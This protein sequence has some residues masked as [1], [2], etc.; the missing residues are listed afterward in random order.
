VSYPQTTTFTTG[1]R[2]ILRKPPATHLSGGGVHEA[3]LHEAEL[4]TTFTRH[5]LSA[6]STSPAPIMVT[7]T[8]LPS[9]TPVAMSHVLQ[10]GLGWIPHLPGAR[11]EACFAQ[12]ATNKYAAA[13]ECVKAAWRSPPGLH[14]TRVTRSL[15]GLVVALSVPR[16]LLHERATLLV[17]YDAPP[18]RRHGR[19]SSTHD[20]AATRA[21]T[22]IL[23]DR[24]QVVAVMSGGGAPTS[25]EVHTTALH[26]GDYL[27]AAATATHAIGAARK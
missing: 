12:E 20:A 27:Y 1:S 7:I 9:G 24:D 17:R 15:R 16:A 14:I 3:A 10:P 23:R 5:G 6:E 13:R 21:L 26:V 22:I 2:E 25:V 18:P 4:R 8:R 11:Y 19:R